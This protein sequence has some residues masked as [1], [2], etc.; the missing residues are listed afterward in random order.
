MFLTEPRR[1]H[2]A[3]AEPQSTAWKHSHS[4]RA[5]SSLTRLVQLL[6]TDT[7][8][9]S[10]PVSHPPS[11]I[12]SWPHRAGHRAQAHGRL[13]RLGALGVFARLWYTGSRLHTLL[14]ARP[15]Q[16]HFNSN[17]RLL[18]HHTCARRCARSITRTA[19]A[20]PCTPEDTH[21]LLSLRLHP[22]SLPPS[23]LDSARTYA[24]PSHT[25]PGDSSTQQRK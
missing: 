23:R 13:Q 3:I 16:K 1:R 7:P 21:F 2:A 5:H 6:H 25:S 19:Q 15:S 8:T 11:S 12:P 9:P 10:L 18:Q 4:S 17:F 24:G 14:P 22:H 20:V